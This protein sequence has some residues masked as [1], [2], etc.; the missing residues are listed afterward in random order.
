MQAEIPYSTTSDEVHKNRE[1]R[2]TKGE[3]HIQQR[4]FKKLSPSS[5]VTPNADA[6]I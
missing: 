2:E 4:Q 3:T 5:I 1:K 6:W